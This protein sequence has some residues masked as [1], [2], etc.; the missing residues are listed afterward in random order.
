MQ[1]KAPQGTKK[2]KDQIAKAANQKKGGAKV[3]I[4]YI[5]RNGPR[6]RQKKNQSMPSSL[7]DPLMKGSL[8]VSLSSA[9]TSPSQELS[10]NIKSQDPLLALC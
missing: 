4:S 6:E 5:R 2:S 3:F 7:T 8:Q 10:K 9:D 1:A